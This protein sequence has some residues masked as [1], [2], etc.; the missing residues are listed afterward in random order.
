LETKH[1]KQNRTKQKQ[2]ESWWWQTY[3]NLRF[4]ETKMKLHKTHKHTK[5]TCQCQNFRELE[6]GA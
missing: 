2:K 3:T 5:E 1:T 4:L 6:T